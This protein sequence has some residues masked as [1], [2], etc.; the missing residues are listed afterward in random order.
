MVFP[1]ILQA[2]SLCLGSFIGEDL[3]IIG[4]TRR[5]IDF[6]GKRAFSLI[7][8]PPI[9]HL[10]RA[11]WKQGGEE[12]TQLLTKFGLVEQAID[13]AIETGAF[14]NAF[15]FTRASMKEKLPEVHY[16]YAMHLEDEGRFKEAEDEFIK[17]GKPKEAIDLYVHQ[18]DW[19][20][21]MRVAEQ[22]DPPSI[23]DIYIAQAGV[24]FSFTKL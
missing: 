22:Y 20:S 8:S 9:E 3:R 18:Q 1:E 11:S 21:A 17:A 19:Q 10:L 2:S 23:P 6:Y 13:Y 24:Y 14:K 15:E 5:L 4:A 16:K 12:G 7:I